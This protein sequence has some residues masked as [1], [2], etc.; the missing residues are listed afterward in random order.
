VSD[1]RLRRLERGAAPGDVAAAARLLAE[2]VR[3]GALDRER[4]ALAAYAGDDASRTA[5]AAAGPVEAGI[6]EP[7]EALRAGVAAKERGERAD[8]HPRDVL[9][10][11]AR[12]L[13][14]WG[15]PACVRAAV[16]AARATVPAWRARRP[17]DETVPE[18]VA[19]AERL[20]ASPDG[21]ETR[22]AADEAVDAVPLGTFGGE[23]YGQ[24]ALAC[25]RAVAAE[26]GAGDPIR[27]RPLARPAAEAL[28]ADLVRH[29]AEVE[30]VERAGG[31]EVLAVSVRERSPALWD[32]LQ[33][34]VFEEL[35]LS[36]ET[37]L[38]LDGHGTWDDRAS[39]A[40]RQAAL[41]LWHPS[42]TWTAVAA[43]VRDEIAPWALA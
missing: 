5:L 11:W 14:R 19:T 9:T 17:G 32:V 43:A 31:S 6:L 21:E 3:S 8:P 41:P 30:V 15:K 35:L 23:G 10:G 34:Y 1:A 36:K 28:R 18:L 4:L 25:L 24:A 2:R 38:R 42:L 33:R 7:L 37:L 39:A 13:R 26:H 27:T 40:V 20:A 12:G 29:G 16:A 22:R